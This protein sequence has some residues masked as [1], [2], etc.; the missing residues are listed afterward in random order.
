[1]G[2]LAD[3]AERYQCDSNAA[4]VQRLVQQATANP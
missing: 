1:V 3:L 2:A 4:V